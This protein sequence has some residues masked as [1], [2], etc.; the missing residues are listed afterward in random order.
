MVRRASTLV[1]V[2][3]ALVLGLG[4]LGTISWFVMFQQPTDPETKKSRPR[5]QFAEDRAPPPAQPLAFDSR[6]AMGYLE[7]ICK[8]GTRISGSEG[9][10]KQQEML[11]KHFEAHGAK[12]EFQRFTARQLSEGKPVE[13]ANLV[14]SWFPEKQR[15]VILC[16][17]YDTR[18]I[19]DQE[20]DRRKWQDGLIAAND[21][22]SGPALL[23]ELAHGMKGLKTEVGVDFVL[24]DGEEYIF[25]PRGDKYFF[26]SEHFAQAYLAR[27]SPSRY[28]GA[29]LV[30][31]IAG[32]EATFPVEQ[33][34]RFMAGALVQQV[35]DIAAEVKSN[36]FLRRDGPE[37][38][39]DHLALNRAGIPA[40]DI[41]DFSYPHWHRLSDLPENCSAEPMEQ[42]ARVLWVW[43]QRAK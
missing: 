39:D 37:V 42:V 3:I 34:S 16:A 30:D 1:V 23:M 13:M 5:D 12:V 43:L 17:H 26:G 35:W 32:K 14:A 25:D 4:L 11:R 2:L 10:K 27:K 19:A 31:M 28:V 7:D 18:P 38:Y 8:I 6:R 15:R 22:A 9:M 29:I 21:G 36:R 24:F 33:G 41:I 40:I 20:P